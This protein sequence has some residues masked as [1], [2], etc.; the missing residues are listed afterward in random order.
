MEFTAVRVRARVTSEIGLKCIK[1]MT[2]IACLCENQAACI[3]S[4]II[5]FKQKPVSVDGSYRK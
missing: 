3:A 2:P 4:E 1:Y 5:L